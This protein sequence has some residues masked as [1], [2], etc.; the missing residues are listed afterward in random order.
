M[1]NRLL[2][3]LF[4]L[5]GLNG[6]A[7]KSQIQIAKNSLGKLQAS[8]A[9]KSDHKKQLTV[10]GEGIKAIDAAQKDKKT[11]NWPETWAIKAYLSS[12]VSLIDDNTSNAEKHYGLAIE[13]VEQANKLDKFQ[14]N[15][16]L[17]KAATNNINVKKQSEGNNAFDRNDFQTA[18]DLLKQVS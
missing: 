13:A 6:F 1:K 2:L 15:S 9:S 3:F 7:Q 4:L 8:I 5:L 18:F 17:I 16:G 11:K 14:D 10:I 12:Y